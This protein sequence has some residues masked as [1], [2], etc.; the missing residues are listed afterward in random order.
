MSVA[1]VVEFSAIL[2]Y[3]VKRSLPSFVGYLCHALK[4][5]HYARPPITVDLVQGAEQRAY[6]I[7]LGRTPSYG[8]PERDTASIKVG[9]EGADR[10]VPDKACDRRHDRSPIII[11]AAEIVGLLP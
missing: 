4:V 1:Q 7:G 9:L 8:R 10:R 3:A 5:I 6:D 2:D 11:E